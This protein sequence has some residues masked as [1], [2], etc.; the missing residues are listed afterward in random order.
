MLREWRDGVG[1]VAAEWQT[2]VSES[3]K[4]V[5]LAKHHL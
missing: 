5:I 1:G 3:E 4:I 2:A